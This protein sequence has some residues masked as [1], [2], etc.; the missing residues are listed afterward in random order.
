MRSRLAEFEASGLR[1]ATLSVQGIGRSKF[2]TWSELADR[3]DRRAE[4]FRRLP[5]LPAEE[6]AAAVRV[7]KEW[8]AAGL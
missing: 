6:R 2:Y 8:E 5:D 7:Y 3:F 1:G 4:L